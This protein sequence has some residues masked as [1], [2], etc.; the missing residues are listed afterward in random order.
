M[1]FTSILLIASVSA[2]KITTP[3]ATLAEAPVPSQDQRLAQIYN[4]GEM[5]QA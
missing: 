1:K 4:G 2:I 3:E 5:T